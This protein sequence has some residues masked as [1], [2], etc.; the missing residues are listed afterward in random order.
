MAGSLVPHLVGHRIRPVGEPCQRLGES[1]R[2]PLA[3]ARRAAQ[4]FEPAGLADMEEL[5]R[6]SAGFATAGWCG[7]AECEARVKEKTAATIRCLPLA[8]GTG[9]G[10]CIVCGRRAAE[11]ATWAQAY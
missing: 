1:E 3:V 5:L 9:E 10:A 4:T 7:S 8:G 6:T 2:R 11:Q